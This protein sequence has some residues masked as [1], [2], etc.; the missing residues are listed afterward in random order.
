MNRAIALDRNQR[1]AYLY[2]F[3]S[4]VELGN[5]EQADEDIDSV[6]LFYPRFV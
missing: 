1:E 4:N 3:L 5:G 6:L 2:R